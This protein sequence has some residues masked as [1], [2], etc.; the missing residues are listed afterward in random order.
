MIGKGRSHAMLWAVLVTLAC[1]GD[2]VAPTPAVCHA[3]VQPIV[4][5]VG[6][7][8]AI[9]PLASMGCV[10]IAANL[11]NTDSAEYL[12]VPQAS[13]T[14]PDN[15]SSFKLVGGAPI[16]AAPPVAAL[17]QAPAPSPA[18]QFHD[19]LRLMEQEGS[20]PQTAGPPA[21][22]GVVGLALAPPAVITVGDQRTFKVLAN[23]SNSTIFSFVP[24][25]AQSVGAHVAIYVDNSA[26]A[27]GR[28]T[29]PELD[30]MRDVFDTLLYPVDVGA[31]GS[32][33]DIDHNGL[34]IVLMSNVINQLV[35]KTQCQTSGYVSGFF[36]GIDIDPSTRTAWNNGEVFYTI[37]GD[38]DS[39]LSCAHPVSQVKRVVPVTF[40]HEFQH[41]ISYNQHVLLRG[42][43]G[44]VL[45]LNEG[46]S[47]YAEERGGRAFLQA[48]DSAHF[49]DYVRGDLYNLGQYLMNPGPYA[50]VNA[51]G[52][53]SLA[54]RG[55]YWA[56]VRFLV[57]QFTTD[58]TLAAADFLTRQMVG[59]SNTGT[60]N[61]QLR[62]GAA[63]AT[64]ARRWAFANWVSDLPDSL[65]GYT[66]PA[67]MR[68]KHW[69]FRSA[70]PVLRALCT[71][72]GTAQLPD[73]FPL[74]APGGPGAA[75]NVSGTIYA[76]SAG[77]YQRALQAASGAQ[78][79]LLFSDGNGSLLQGSVGPR[80]NVLRIR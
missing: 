24:A 28:L 62:I 71:P 39:L 22:A 57:D 8:T 61:V 35:T 58:T 54:Q 15:H 14:T 52:S 42:G 56:F 80:L 74:N 1:N 12:I 9:D 59:T 19:R 46:L 18:E 30:A 69:A 7:D 25:T 76:G 23:I 5:S 26:P 40:V 60:D 33:S 3:G 49:C 4:L 21:P 27:A 38:P 53:G 51:S 41:M 32:E 31:F 65:P 2:P 10:I 55:A 6:A 43:N 73:P 29:T 78:F 66:A 13:T 47:H 77:T 79:T 37:V 34:V 16:V 44:E 63:F 75:I 67:T 45:W 20:Y 72:T 50:L 48:G 17:F 11:S 64:V 68:Y 36:F 70:Y